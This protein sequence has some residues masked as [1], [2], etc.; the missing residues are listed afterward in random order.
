[1]KGRLFSGLHTESGETMLFISKIFCLCVGLNT[2]KCLGKPE[3]DAQECHFFP[4]SSW[5]VTVWRVVDAGEQ[6]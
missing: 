3:V 5:L 2:K 4:S 1:M 6:S